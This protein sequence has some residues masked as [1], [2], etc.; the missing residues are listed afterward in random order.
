[1]R[2]SP[3]R[4]IKAATAASSAMATPAPSS[5]SVAVNQKGSVV[6]EKPMSQMERMG[7][8]VCLHGKGRFF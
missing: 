6:C 7:C 4:S 2:C 5:H 8:H 1:M 3:N